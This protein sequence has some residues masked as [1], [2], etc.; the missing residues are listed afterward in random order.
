MLKETSISHLAPVSDNG[1]PVKQLD[2]DLSFLNM[3]SCAGEEPVRFI[4]EEAHETVALFGFD[5]YE[6][7]GYAFSE[8]DPTASHSV[9]DVNEDQAESDEEDEEEEM[10]DEDLFASIGSGD[11]LDANN[12]IWD[13]RAYFLRTAAMRVGVIVARY[14][15]FIQKLEDGMK[16]WVSYGH[17]QPH[18]N[19]KLTPHVD[20]Q[21]CIHSP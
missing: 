16:N 5:N 6:W 19:G 8:H 10:P 1:G 9:Q 12:A 2:I 20:A 17:H 7:T 15:Y 14:T 4:V 11:V 18:L 21:W 13:P 3:E